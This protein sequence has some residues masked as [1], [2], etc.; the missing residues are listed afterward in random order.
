[1]KD[2]QNRLLQY[3]MN[4]QEYP[5]VKFYAILKEIRFIIILINNKLLFD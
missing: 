3:P 4:F 2:S 5:R 1:M